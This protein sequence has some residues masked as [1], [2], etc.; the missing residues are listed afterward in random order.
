MVILPSSSMAMP[1]LLRCL[2]F[3][4]EKCYLLLKI[5]YKQCAL[6]DGLVDESGLS[7]PSSSEGISGGDAAAKE[8]VKHVADFITVSAGHEE[9]TVDPLNITIA[10]APHH[11]PAMGTYAALLWKGNN[12]TAED[13]VQG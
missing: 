3:F 2:R 8:G 1:L 4:L 9:G 5:C 13:G 6:Q 11:L 12:K 10:D 7:D